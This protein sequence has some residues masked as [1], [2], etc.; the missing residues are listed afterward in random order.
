MQT[1]LRNHFIG[2]D[3]QC[4]GSVIRGLVGL[5]T[6]VQGIGVP[7][8]GVALILGVDRILD[9]TRTTVNVSGDLT[10]SVVMENW[11]HDEISTE[12]DH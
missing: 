11:L 5:P 10:A 12:Q 8:E 9:M 1:D 7:P 6:I 3:L 2:I 4:V